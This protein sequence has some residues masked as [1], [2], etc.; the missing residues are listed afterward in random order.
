MTFCNLPSGYWNYGNLSQ[1]LTVLGIRYSEMKLFDS[2]NND[3]LLHMKSTSGVFLT[4]A[5]FFAL[6][7]FN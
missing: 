7:N 5:T 6:C 3:I 2:I 4:L 1:R